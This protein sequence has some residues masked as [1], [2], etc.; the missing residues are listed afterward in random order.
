MNFKREVQAAVA[1]AI[2]LLSLLAITAVAIPSG[3]ASIAAQPMVT[4]SAQVTGVTFSGPDSSA[5]PPT[6]TITGTGFGAKPK[7]TSDDS[8]SCGTYSDNGDTYKTNL[9]FYEDHWNWEAGYSSAGTTSC[10]GIIVTTW[11]ADK[12]VFTF[13]DAY[14]TSVNWVVSNTDNY[15]VAVKGY[16]WGGL[17]SGLS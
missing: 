9:S 15:A 1:G 5:T 16:L 10:I 3:A 14:G 6:V 4:S 17:V 8:N 2:G 12:I 13:G 11:K 7:G